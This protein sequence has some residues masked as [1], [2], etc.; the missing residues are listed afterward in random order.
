MPF[1][2]A[3]LLAVATAYFILADVRIRQHRSIST[4]QYTSANVGIRQHTSAYVSI[5]ILYLRINCPRE[6]GSTVASA[7]G[8][9]HSNLC[10]K[11][12]QQLAKHVSS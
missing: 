3:E 12:F 10:I 1:G 11:V 8:L 9:V 5:P 6:C 4:R 7:A 2:G